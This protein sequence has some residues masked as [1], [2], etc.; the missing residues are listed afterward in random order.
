MTFII[1]GKDKKIS[2]DAVQAF[3]H[4]VANVLFAL[5]P[6]DASAKRVALESGFTEEQ[7]KEKVESLVETLRGDNDDIIIPIPIWYA[8]VSEIFIRLSANYLEEI[9]K[10][11]A[12]DRKLKEQGLDKQ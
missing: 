2:K 1:D 6:L 5:T 11:V 3:H 10:A 12:L 4:D 9:N 7:F 8:A